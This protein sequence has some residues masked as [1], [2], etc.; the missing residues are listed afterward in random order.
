MDIYDKRKAVEPL[1]IVPQFSSVPHTMVNVNDSESIISAF[2]ILHL[3][4]PLFKYTALQRKLKL[5]FH[6]KRKLDITFG[7]R[8][9]LLKCLPTLG[10]CSLMTRFTHVFPRSI[11]G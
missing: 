6:C 5:G 11:P 7:L 9:I 10:N 4:F 3:R 8:P 1:F 2:N